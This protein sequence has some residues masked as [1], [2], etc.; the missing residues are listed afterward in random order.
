MET[1]GPYGPR[2]FFKNQARRAQLAT[3]KVGGEV[4]AFCTKCKMTLNHTILAMVGT[5][6]ARVRCNTCNGDHA[7]RSAPGKA[8]PRSPASS[9]TRRV[10]KVVISW[11]ERLAGRDV[12]GAVK[13]SAQETF[14]PEQ[15]VNH[16][17][18][19]VGI[20]SA[21]RGDKVDI[22]FR[23]D[24]KT[25][26]HGRGG[27]EGSAKPSFRPPNAASKGPADKRPL[28]D[29][30]QDSEM[31]TVVREDLDPEGAGES[32]VAPP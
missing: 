3:N 21:I 8:T 18:F 29:G 16:P 12:A 5:K 26:I 27:A 23:G 25:L 20:V 28:D 13:Y 2:P 11:E 10:A 19:G 7:Y 24:Q 1:S 31:E 9:R 4:D 15:L 30:G 22:D 32:E 17:S 6:L 14:A